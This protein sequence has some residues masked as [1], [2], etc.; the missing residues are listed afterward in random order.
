MQFVR[1]HLG[2]IKYLYTQI[3]I[4]KT[5]KEIIFL[6]R[7]TGK[8]YLRELIRLYNSLFLVF[9]I[10]YQ[11]KKKEYNK[12]QQI[13]VDLQRCIKILKYVDEK[14]EKSGINRQR[15]RQFWR[16][17]Y[18]NGNLRKEVF[19]DLLKEINQIK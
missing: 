5:L 17:F 1:L 11:K 15:R 19:D 8:A 9:D 18:S 3:K 4:K 2:L 14:M 10:E 13:K 12:Y 6:F 16:D 7:D